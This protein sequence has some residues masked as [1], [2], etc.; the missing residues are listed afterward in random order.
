MNG[1]AGMPVRGTSIV[2]FGIREA[3]LNPSLFNERA[4]DFL[5]Y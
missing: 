3:G 1:G 5:F 2:P 4:A